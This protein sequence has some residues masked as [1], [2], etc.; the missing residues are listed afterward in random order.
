MLTRV[1]I[2]PYVR[3]ETHKP[4]PIGTLSSAEAFLCC[5]EAGEKENKSARGTMGRGK[6][7][8]RKALDHIDLN[9]MHRYVSGDLQN[10]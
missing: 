9:Q 8:Q 5:R 2:I 1:K 4:Y 10:D 7:E 6:R 3:I